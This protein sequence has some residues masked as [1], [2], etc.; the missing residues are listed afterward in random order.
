VDP[1][2]QPRYVCKPSLEEAAAALAA[3]PTA[4]PNSAAFF[5]GAAHFAELFAEW[6]RS[7][8]GATEQELPLK[9]AYF[10]NK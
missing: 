6:V 3:D 2:V 4:G 10:A 9:F 8:V 1:P 5:A 7:E